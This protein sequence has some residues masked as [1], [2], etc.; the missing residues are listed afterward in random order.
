M[1]AQARCPRA[2]T[3]TL[4]RAVKVGLQKSALSLAASPIASSSKWTVESQDAHDRVKHIT[5]FHTRRGFSSASRTAQKPASQTARVS[6]NLLLKYAESPPA[7][8]KFALDSTSYELLSDHL[9]QSIFGT[10]CSMAEPR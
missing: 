3:S 9:Q 5:Q 8:G 7:Y 1:A 6:E 10:L 4:A 2:Y